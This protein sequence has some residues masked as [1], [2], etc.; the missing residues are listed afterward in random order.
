MVWRPCIQLRLSANCAWPSLTGL[1][2]LMLSLA[3]P[4]T[5]KIGRLLMGPRSGRP[6]MPSCCIRP[7]PVKFELLAETR[8]TTPGAKF[9]E[10]VGADGAGVAGGPEI[11]AA[12]DYRRCRRWWAAARERA[13][14]IS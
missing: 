3:K 13:P 8:T 5:L 6:W 12:D 4:V 10:Q 1:R 9:I 14:G 7:C 2:R 11:D